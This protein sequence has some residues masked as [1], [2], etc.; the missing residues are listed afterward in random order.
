MITETVNSSLCRKVLPPLSYKLF[1][2]L[3]QIIS[4]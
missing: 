2:M 3:V 4:V 1:I